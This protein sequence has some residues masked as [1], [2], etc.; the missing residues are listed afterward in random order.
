MKKLVGYVR[1]STMAQ[2]KDGFNMEDKERSI[3]M[4]CDLYYQPDEYELVIMHEKGRSAKSL[5]RPE[6]KKLVAMTAH[7][8][9]DALIVYSLDRLTRM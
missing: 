1:E 6:I 7:R 8:E 4:Y 3:R 2:V 5:N 9:Y